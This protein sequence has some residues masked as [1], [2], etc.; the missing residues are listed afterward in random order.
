L[1]LAS[2]VAGGSTDGFAVEAGGERDPK[3]V[4]YIVREEMARALGDLAQFGVNGSV[5]VVET[6]ALGRLEGAAGAAE[7]GA[8]RPPDGDN[9]FLIG[10]QTKLVVGAAIL[11]LVADGKMTL[12][13]DVSSYVPEADEAAGVTI[14]QLLT[15]TSGLGDGLRKFDVPAPP[16]SRYLGFEELY[17]LSVEE[18][19]QFPAGTAWRYNNFG[20]ALLAKAIEAAAG[21]GYEDFI[22]LFAAQN[23]NL[24]TTGVARLGFWPE[25]PMA[26]G[27]W[28]TGEEPLDLGLA[29]PLSWAKG[30]G[31]MFSTANEMASL[32]RALGAASDGALSFKAL[33]QSSAATSVPEM[34]N[35]GYGVMER[36]FGGRLTWGH[37]GFIHG[38]MSYSGFDISS[39][40]SFSIMA[41]LDGASGTNY[42]LLMERLSGVVQQVLAV[43]SF[44]GSVVVREHNDRHP[45]SYCR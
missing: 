26:H 27:Y 17:S 8:T 25:G 38:Y 36:T 13:D 39:G 30:A 9:I 31:D 12:D 2:G 34:P 19:R 20:Y 18:G 24:N 29:H 35:Y 28:S 11:S 3:N 7:D 15:H 22:S 1:F 43:A 40:T 5:L 42:S 10:S 14:G 6:D 37:G 32:M 23:F 4:C 21:V 44:A 16:P 45:V 41:A 33:M